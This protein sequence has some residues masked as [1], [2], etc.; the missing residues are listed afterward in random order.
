MKQIKQIL[1]GTLLML[2]ALKSVNAQ[3]WKRNGVGLSTSE[4][5]C[6]VDISAPSMSVAWGILS[7]FSA[8]SC[9]GQ[10][11]YFTKTT[12][13]NY[14]TARQIPLPQ[15]ATPV[16]ITA[17]DAKTAWIAVTDI[18]TETQG[19][20][21]KTTD[22]GLNWQAQS[23][24]IF[25]DALRFIH[26]FNTNEGVAVGDS[27]VFVTTN[28]GTNWISKGAIPVDVAK[29]G[30]GKTKFLLNAYEIKDNTIWLGDIFGYFYKSTDKGNTWNRMP[31]AIFPS[32][33]K[34]IAF[35]DQNYG[36]A[37]ASRYIGGGSGSSGGVD[38][39]YSV[40]TKDGGI[41]WSPMPINLNSP[42][43]ADNL[44]KYDVGYLPG[45]DNTFIVTSEYD[46]TLAA[47]SAITTDGGKNWRLLDSTERHTVCAFTGPND[48]YTGGYIPDFNKGI[49]K[50]GGMAGVKKPMGLA[51]EVLL[52]PNPAKDFVVVNVKS[53]SLSN[54]T[55]RLFDHTG[56]QVFVQT[57][58]LKGNQWKMDLS[59]QA[60]GFYF[61]SIETKES[62]NSVFVQ[63]LKFSKI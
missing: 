23:T 50:L 33:V 9:G 11:P 29:T 18:A 32:A 44:A 26:F 43:I 39:D 28:G 15:N 63:T 57:E 27:S 1:T 53:A 22:G 60:N 5:V 19:A 21:Y 45:T 59:T 38:Q 37:V 58:A 54:T 16:C 2:C 4:G 10:V 46:S 40:Y 34:G 14:W 47:F 3:T 13:G 41:N 12:E 20:I 8:G 17:L 31:N 25:P 6:V 49:Y 48:G 52:Y 56:K 7:V 61:L 55:L 42:N 35:K 62:N 51:S 36:M 30:S 24:A